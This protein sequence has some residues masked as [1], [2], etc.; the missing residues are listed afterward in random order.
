MDD[1][2]EMLRE[3][4]RAKRM[5]KDT[6]APDRFDAGYDEIYKAWLKN[7]IQSISSPVP[8]SCRSVEDKGSKA[9]IEL[10]EVKR[11]AREIMPSL[12]KIKMLSR[13]QLRVGKAK[14]RFQ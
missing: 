6:V 2:L 3:W 8:N 1:T 9:V 5:K 4:K 12:L 7:N 11:E 10:Q 14:T 13:R